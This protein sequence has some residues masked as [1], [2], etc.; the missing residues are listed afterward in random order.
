MYVSLKDLK[1]NRWN[2]MK[3]CSDCMNGRR[4]V[5]WELLISNTYMW[6]FDLIFCWLL[7]TFWCDVTLHN[8]VYGNKKSPLIQ[9]LEDIIVIQ[10]F[11]RTLKNVYWCSLG[12][13]Q[14][15]IKNHMMINCLCTNLERY[16]TYLFFILHWLKHIYLVA[17]PCY[18]IIICRRCKNVDL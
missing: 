8:R 4:G 15:Y 3:T 14:K 1:R 17:C 9:D 12:D 11:I 2:I 5:G 13:A 6:T 16:L 7:F 10:T 18:I